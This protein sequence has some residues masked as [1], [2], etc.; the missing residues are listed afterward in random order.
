MNVELRLRVN[1]GD[2]SAF[3]LASQHDSLAKLQMQEK[4]A[5]KKGSFS[6]LILFTR[7]DKVLPKRTTYC[8][9]R[10]DTESNRY[11]LAIANHKAEAPSLAAAENA[12]SAVKVGVAVEV[13]SARING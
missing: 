4:G 5:I 2:L 8:I 7:Y 1:H 3:R 9:S 10:G 11:A 12:S 13:E 6:L